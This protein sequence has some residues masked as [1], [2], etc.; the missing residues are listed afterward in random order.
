[1][2][3][4]GILETAPLATLERIFAQYTT[5]HELLEE[6]GVDDTPLV[7]PFGQRLIHALYFRQKVEAPLQVVLADVCSGAY[8][9][10]MVRPEVLRLALEELLP[11][12]ELNFRRTALRYLANPLAVM[13]SAEDWNGDDADL[14]D[15]LTFQVYPTDGKYQV[16]FGDFVTEFDDAAATSAYLR[17]Q[18]AILQ[19]ALAIAQGAQP[20]PLPFDL[21]YTDWV[22]ERD[23]NGQYVVSNGDEQLQLLGNI[24]GLQLWLELRLAELTTLIA[25][26]EVTP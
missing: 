18:A 10:T 3:S 12:L 1:M 5:L 16:S 17:R 22:P 24:E 13:V 15:E 19:H 6:A 8:Q 25:Q 9:P 7:V 11:R 23:K 21:D 26:L 4:T 2:T 14:D 20:A